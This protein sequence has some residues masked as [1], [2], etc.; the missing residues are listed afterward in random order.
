MQT[1]TQGWSNQLWISF[2]LAV[3]SWV[4]GV[5]WL[6]RQELDRAFLAIGLERS[7][8]PQ[9]PTWHVVILPPQERASQSHTIP[10]SPQ[11]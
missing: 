11:H 1:D 5:L 2:A 6:L 7:A 9:Y 10:P 4:I 8:V 3:T